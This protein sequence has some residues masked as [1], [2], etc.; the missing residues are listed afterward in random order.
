MAGEQEGDWPLVGRERELAT[1]TATISTKAARGI[2]LAGPAGVGKSRLAAEAAKRAAALG[3][4][5]RTLSGHAGLAGV[6]LGAISSMVDVPLAELG[7]GEVLSRVAAAL[8][9]EGP[10][11]ALTVVVDDAHLLDEVTA[12]VIYQLLFDDRVSLVVTVR[13][14]AD[15][16]EP[17]VRFWRD[18]A[19]V[20][21]EV[22]P[23]QPPAVEELLSSVLGGAVES[24]TARWLSTYSEGNPLYLRE[25]VHEGL[26][27][28]HLRDDG[29]LWRLIEPSLS[30]R[31]T[32]L[33]DNRLRALSESQRELLTL[34]AVGEP[35]GL[36]LLEKRAS[37]DDLRGLERRGLLTVK[38]DGRRL[39]TRLAHPLYGELVRSQTPP[40]LFRRVQQVL[41][42]MVEATGA[43]RS[44]DRLRVATWRLDGGGGAEP[45][46]LVDAAQQARAHGDVE[47]AE[48]LAAAA[49]AAG[50]GFAAELLAAQLA[51]L[52]GRTGEADQRL[53]PLA[54]AATT[55]EDMALLATTRMDILAMGLGRLPE[56]LRIG[57]EAER[58]VTPGPPHDEIVAKQ[59]QVLLQSGETAA[60][61]ARLDPLLHRLE[62]RTLASASLAAATSLML[63]GRLN[64]ALEV[65]ERGRLA[66]EG[67]ASG[68]PAL[69]SHLHHDVQVMTLLH[70][71]RL[72]EAAQA[73]RS[74]LDRGLADG[75]AEVRGTC[76]LRYARA[77][78]AQG[79]PGPAARYGREAALLL[80]QGSSPM[81]QRVALTCLSHALAL[82]GRA[83][84]ARAA[85]AELNRLNLPGRSV[86]GTEILLA[87]AWTEVAAGDVGALPRA[88]ER[89]DEAV[90]TAREGGDRILEAAALHDLARLGRADAVAGDLT[91]LAGVVD[92]PLA[93]VRAAH[94]TALAGGDADGLNQVA[95]DFAAL[96]ADLLAAEATAMAATAAG[97]SRRATALARLAVNRWR[98]CDGAIP[99]PLG[100]PPPSQALTARELE[101]TALVAGG[102]TNKE[103]AARFS[104]SVRTVE[105]QLRRAYEKLGVGNRAELADVIAADPLPWGPYV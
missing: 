30:G 48:R 42:D 80:R 28:G 36:G 4:T 37:F 8:A 82:A 23:L 73:A 12:G 93:A 75:S 86:L 100:A 63:V 97:N 92:G 57:E 46:F 62:G 88:I 55:D 25:L 66:Y 52:Q 34:V 79:H 21:L 31:L 91:R 39:D 2:V 35:L 101:V 64:E 61:L 5:V 29:G 95:D 76:S 71:G 68:S 69:G 3:H 67:V 47:L 6:P 16:P 32:A 84:D 83:E 40:V 70:A 87:A 27:S 60:A 53:E 10:E 51:W 74:Q 14:G 77:L 102:S 85:L 45:D 105:T 98:L 18:G 89:L 78:L 11:G 90:A 103:V 22:P 41:A 38:E 72:K 24:A 58:R 13:A 26:A 9:R 94:A 54:S 20:R 59:A 44:T 104:V 96:G 1:V 99:T 7:P 33:V 17:V 43:R 15:A 65:S 49:V 19:A 81:F 56:A 50:G